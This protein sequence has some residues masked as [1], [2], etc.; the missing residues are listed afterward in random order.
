MI[1]A[2]KS[3]NTSMLNVRKILKQTTDM[4]DKPNQST[5]Y[6]H[7]TSMQQIKD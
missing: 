1:S 7:Q 3:P 4:E 5:Y 6:S 2:L